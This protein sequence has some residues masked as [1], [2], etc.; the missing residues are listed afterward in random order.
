[1][2]A[3][4]RRT[5]RQ[6]TRRQRKAARDAGVGKQLRPIPCKKDCPR[7]CGEWKEEERRQVFSH[8][9][10]GLTVNDRKQFLVNATSITQGHKRASTQYFLL[11]GNK[12]VEVCKSFLLKT[13]DIGD[14]TL[15][16]QR[17]NAGD[18]GIAKRDS[19]GG[20][21]KDEAKKVI[22]RQWIERLPAMLP[23]YCRRDSR[24]KY[25]PNSFKNLTN[26]YKMYK[27][28]TPAF[29]SRGTFNSVF[30]G[31]YNIGIHVPK[32]D[33]CLVCEKHNN[34]AISEDSYQEHQQEYKATNDRFLHLQN[35]AKDN[36]KVG[37]QSTAVVSFDLQKVLGTPHGNS[38]L[39]GYSRKLPCYNLTIY[40]SGTKEGICY[41]WT[42]VD[43][44]RGS[45]EIASVLFQYLEEKERAGV[46]HIHFFCDS[47]YGQNKNRA[48]FAMVFAFLGK[49]KCIE[50]VELNYL[51]PGHTY[52]PCDSVHSAIERATDRITVWAPSQWPTIILGARADPKPYVV[53]ALTTE[54][55]LDWKSFSSYLP[56]IPVSKI[57]SA[58]FTAEEM[59][60][61]LTTASDFELVNMSKRRRPGR[62][63]RPM[64]E[65]AY[66]GKQKISSAKYRD[67]QK[68]VTDGVVPTI[69]HREFALLQPTDDAEDRL[70]ETDD[71]E[72]REEAEDE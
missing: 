37:D 70:D 11:K 56:T 29:L 3:N 54:T 53:K 48:V 28:S 12:K 25:L 66:L 31:E 43:A 30:R 15:R 71:E 55:V 34:K 27:M 62:P 42:E 38:M 10:E 20:N 67:L 4:S 18:T 33:K 7:K 60:I 23:H 17:E 2:G 13:L 5:Q 19:R 68:L 47:C 63:T 26:V 51:V 72:S 41:L 46:K 49:A 22:L 61:K 58:L 45:N 8:Y 57:R 39:I 32:K 65:R 50:T 44:R 35:L 40:E 64:A 1:M 9:W 14:K 36:E 21:H 59:K 69:F 24:R 6:N 52:M 16:H